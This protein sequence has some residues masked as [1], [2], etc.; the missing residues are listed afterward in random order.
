MILK[1]M[2]TSLVGNEQSALIYLDLLNIFSTVYNLHSEES[3]LE[4]FN[5]DRMWFTNTS[6]LSTIPGLSLYIPYLDNWI[7]IFKK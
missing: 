5:S 2:K 3:F 7:N 6:W 4:T 1:S